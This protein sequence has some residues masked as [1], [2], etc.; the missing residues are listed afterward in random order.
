MKKIAQILILS[1]IVAIM[2]T[3]CSSSRNTATGMA[4]VS[5]G[6]FTGN[7][8]LNTV[9]YDG[10]V[11]GAVTTVFD[12][13]PP[14]SFIGSTWRLTNSGN[15][16]YT[17][18]NGTSQSIFWSLYNDS[19]LGQMFQ[20]KKIY[21]GDKAKNVETGYRLLISSNDG[22][23]MVLKSPVSVGGSTG[24]VVYTFNKQ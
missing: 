16:M 2:F 14:D 5:R 13:A 4:N 24:Y 19:T 20:F 1:T 3:A 10:L 18:T 22:S 8:V 21:E 23:R 11:R 6:R 15:G 17:L 12:Q 7:W 9:S